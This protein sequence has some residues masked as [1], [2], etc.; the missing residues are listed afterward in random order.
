MDLR[1]KGKATIVTGGA[2]AGIPSMGEK[3]RGDRHS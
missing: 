2:G 1:L 3:V